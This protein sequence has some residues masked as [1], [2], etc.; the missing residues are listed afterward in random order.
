MK[1]KILIVDDEEAARYGIKKALA[2]KDHVLIEAADIG[3]AANLIETEKPDLVLLDINLPDGSGLEFFKRLSN[4]LNPPLAIMITAYGSLDVAIEAIKC[5]AYYYLSKPFEVE[6]LRKQ[7]TNALE[8]LA[9]RREN[10]ILK[11]Q[12]SAQVKYGQLTGSS[13]AM[14][15]VFDLIEKV[16]AADVTVLITGESGTGKELVAREIH[17]RSSRSAKSFVAMNCAALPDTLIE[18]ELFGHEKGAFTGAIAPR[19]GKFEL[20]NGGTLFL[21][22]IGDM[23]LST[24]AKVLRAIEERAIE[25]LGGNKPLMVDVRFISATNKNLLEETKKAAFRED[26]YYRLRVVVIELPS[27]KER[28]EDIPLLVDRFCE[29][30]ATKHNL[31][32]KK[33]STEALTKLCQHDWPGNV[34]ELRN[35]VEHCVVLSSGDI[36]ELKDLP[37]ELIQGTTTKSLSENKISIYKQL[38]Y[39]EAKAAFEREYLTSI[40]EDCHDN[41]SR[42]AEVMGIH[43]QT[44]QYKLT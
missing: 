17:K 20:A 32:K 14:K 29:M 36:L 41:I 7:V 16:A 39:E 3:S 12:L 28:K 44:L 9:L 24:Q 21:D 23:S 19:K 15:K 10:R 27:L 40:L 30:L 42:A 6:D 34:R 2:S 25:R 38:T 35:F 26:L 22:E 8:S 31:S 5:G 13:P 37:L 11:E 43:R 33:F 18:S 1:F 4:S